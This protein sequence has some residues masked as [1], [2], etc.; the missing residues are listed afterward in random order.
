MVHTVDAS[1][2]FYLTVILFPCYSRTKLLINVD[3]RQDSMRMP[4]HH[5]ASSFKRLNAWDAVCGL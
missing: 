3:T 4:F 1:S 5:A 2:G